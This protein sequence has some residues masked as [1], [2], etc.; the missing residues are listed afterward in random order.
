MP[1]HSDGIMSQIP[2]AFASLVP[3]SSMGMGATMGMV[4][5]NKT[6]EQVTEEEASSVDF[7]MQEE[8]TDP[9]ISDLMWRGNVPLFPS[10]L[11]MPGSPDFNISR[12]MP[13]PWEE[14]Q[15]SEPNVDDIL[16]QVDNPD[17]LWSNIQ[18][19]QIDQFFSDNPGARPL[20]GLDTNAREELQKDADDL[21]RVR[22]S[23]WIGNIWEEALTIPG[24]TFSI[25]TEALD[26]VIDQVE[27][28]ASVEERPYATTALGGRFF[29]DEAQ[30]RAWAQEDMLKEIPMRLPGL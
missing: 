17:T 20:V 19:Y 16:D 13:L 6:F 14:G 5:G 22:G 4:F 1:F 9:N 28:E 27:A 26:K 7:D 18:P 21:L 29:G 10:Q 2:K 30:E 25:A 3:L 23:E 8:L 24:D 15:L 12:A 11:P